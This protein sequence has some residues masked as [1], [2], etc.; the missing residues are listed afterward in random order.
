MAYVISYNLYMIKALFFDIDGT[1]VSFKTHQ[2][3]QS[4]VDAIATAKAKGVSVFISTGRPQVLINNISALTDKKLID[5][6]ITMN[7]AYCFA[8]ENVISKQPISHHSVT[9]VLDY[10]WKNNI[11]CVVVGEKDI[12]ICKTNQTVHDLFY[13]QLKSPIDFENK[14]PEDA[15]GGKDIF[16][17]TPFVNASQEKELM[18]LISDCEPGRWHPAFIDLTANGCT[19]Q[20][21]IN[22]IINYFGLDLSETMAFGD[23]G[24]DIPMLR[25]AKIGV[26]MGNA[27]DQVKNAANY[28]TSSVDDNGIAN[29]LKHFEVI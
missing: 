9:T 27:I 5:G 2:I 21:G 23:G 10:T 18:T 25:H 1:L 22:D 16:Q 15:I 8:G 20:K 29:A 7:G 3:P 28:V 6:Y 13:V 11:P 4:T 12:C 17:L 26:A 14:T 24:N 19:K